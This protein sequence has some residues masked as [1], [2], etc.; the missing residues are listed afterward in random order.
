MSARSILP[1][2]ERTHAMA[3]MTPRAIQRAAL[4]PW[5]SD[6]RAI[7]LC[8]PARIA[9]RFNAPDLGGIVGA[10]GSIVPRDL[11]DHPGEVGAI[12]KDGRRVLISWCG[13][14]HGMWLDHDAVTWAGRL[15]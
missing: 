14:D 5:G 15:L 10:G 2:G 12:S 4:A 7:R 11:L 9:A 6:A 13:G 3:G 1:A 8:D